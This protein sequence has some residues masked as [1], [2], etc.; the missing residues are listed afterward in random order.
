MSVLD[1]FSMGLG[2]LWRLPKMQSRSISAENFTGE[3]GKAGMATE[4]TGAA[5]AR[6]GAGLEGV[7]FGGY[8]L[9]A[10]S[11]PWPISTVPALSRACGSPAL[12][13]EAR[14]RS[15]SCAS[16][17]TARTS[18]R[19]SA[20][21]LTSSLP[22]WGG[23]A[24]INSL[25][26][27]V[28]PSRGF[29]CFWQMPFRTALPHHPAK[30]QRRGSICYYQINY[31]LTDVPE[32]AAYFHAQFRR[33]NPAALQ[34]RL[35]HPGRHPGPGH[36]VGT[37]LAVGVNNSRWWGEGEIKFYLDGDGELPDHLRHRHRGL[38]RRRLRLGGRTGSTS[39]IPRRSWACTR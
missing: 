4:G 22:G 33:V 36:Y 23:Y 26:V 19:W 1:G 20:R 39:R 12:C 37:Y 34:G 31:A 35:H 30:P 2:D 17:G 7:A 29:N 5:C 28:N 8:P 11:S 18:P 27:A 9:A 14:P 38:L 32:D 15:S 10:R 21:W 6:P 3:K 24:Q 13:G 16:T 25:P